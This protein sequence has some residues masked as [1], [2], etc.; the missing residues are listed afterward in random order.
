MVGYV[1]EAGN[2]IIQYLF[3]YEYSGLNATFFVQFY[4]LKLK[5]NI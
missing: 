5:L 4:I 1:Y 2:Y 3:Y